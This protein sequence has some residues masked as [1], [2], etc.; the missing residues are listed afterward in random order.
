MRLD[1]KGRCCGRKPLVYKR[2]HPP[3]HHYC[4]RC[5]RAYD[6]DDGEQIENWAWKRDNEGVFYRNT[7]RHTDAAASPDNAKT[8]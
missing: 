4:P 5:D 6:L 3:P 1:D 2:M 8:S 7:S